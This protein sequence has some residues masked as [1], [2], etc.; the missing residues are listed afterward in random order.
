MAPFWET[1]RNGPAA[2]PER[3]NRRGV[4]LSLGRNHPRQQHMQNPVPL[5]N[6]CAPVANSD[7]LGT[8]GKVGRGRGPAAPP[9]SPHTWKLSSFSD[10]AECQ[11]CSVSEGYKWRELFSTK[12]LFSCIKLLV[13]VAEEAVLDANLQASLSGSRRE[14]MGLYVHLEQSIS[15]GPIYLIFTFLS[16]LP[17]FPSLFLFFGKLCLHTKVPTLHSLH[18][19]WGWAA[20]GETEEMTTLWGFLRL[21]ALSAPPAI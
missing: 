11:L 7:S 16:A 9:S 17:H 6:L 5:S 1:W 8:W 21:Q 13:F 14:E 10:W 3:L 19:L 20:D 4:N 18:G 2:I 15:P 12:Q